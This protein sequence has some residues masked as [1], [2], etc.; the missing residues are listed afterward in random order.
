MTTQRPLHLHVAAI[1]AGNLDSRLRIPRDAPIAE[2]SDLGRELCRAAHRFNADVTSA[3]SW[4]SP[5]SFDR[6]GRHGLRPRLLT[7]VSAAS[8]YSAAVSV[9]EKECNVRL[10][11]GARGLLP[12]G[13]RSTISADGAISSAL[14]WDRRTRHVYPE[15]GFP[16]CVTPFFPGT[17]AALLEAAG[18]ERVLANAEPFVQAFL[19]ILQIGVLETELGRNPLVPDRHKPDVIDQ[20]RR[21][22]TDLA[23]WRGRLDALAVPELRTSNAAPRLR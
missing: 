21:L 10:S 18:P 6:A 17:V 4:A 2:L 13:F 7:S 1:L 14:D 20:A 16:L 23:A 9:D 19:C 8:C 5:W 15:L 11:T 22:E 12:F 3:D